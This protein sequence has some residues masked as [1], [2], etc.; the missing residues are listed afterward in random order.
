MTDT[1]HHPAASPAP[2]GIDRLYF[3]AWRWHFYA[4]LFVLPFLLMLAVTGFFMMLFT[5]YLPEYGERL[6]VTPAGAALPLAEQAAAAQ[7]AV[8]GAVGVVEY[9]APYTPRNPALFQVA[10]GQA[11]VVVALDP[12]TGEVLRRTVAG[13]T[14]NLF[15]ERIHGTLLLGDTG[16]RLIEIASGLGLLMIVTGLYLAWP[17]RDGGWRE[18]LIPDFSLRG[19]SLWKSLHR[20]I[21]TWISLVLAFFLITGLAWTGIWGE[22]FVQAWSTFPAEKWEAVPLSDATHLSL[23]GSGGKQVPWGLEQTP[24]PQSG[25]AA[26]AA[27]LPEGTPID[28]AAMERIA[29]AVGIAGRFRVGAPKDGTGVWTISQNSMSYDGAPPTQD[30]TLHVDQYTGRILADVRYADYAPAAKA[31]AVGIALHEGQVGLANFALNALFCLAVVLACVSGAVM[32]WKRRPERAGRLAAPP[33]P[34]DVPLARG[35]VLI[36]VLMSMAFPL[37]G[38]TLLAVLALDLILLSRLPAL[39]RALS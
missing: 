17:R 22:R 23:N 2:A 13:E 4:G 26:G 21:G 27:I 30:R 34:Q 24:L 12:Y 29:R 36:A 35:V 7:A 25:S 3:A 11:G 6:A 28:L 15:L 39:K 38:L 5:T 37:L 31:M 33:L 10:D 18:M 16:D 9:I 19:R 32:W 1:I 8:P 20:T 14:W